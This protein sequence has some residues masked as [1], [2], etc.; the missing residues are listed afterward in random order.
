MPI[1]H[2]AFDVDGTL[3]DT[4]G[5]L[6]RSL[7]QALMQVV[8]SSHP[9]DVLADACIGRTETFTMNALEV[10]GDKRAEL[11][12]VWNRLTQE[13]R[14]G[15]SEV[16]DGA[17]AL[18]DALDE[19][20]IQHGIVTTRDA[21]LLDYDLGAA[22]LLERFSPVVTAECTRKHKP[23]P[24]PL[25]RYLE[26]TGADA[27]ETLYVG[28]TEGDRLC[29]ERAGVPFCLATWGTERSVD[30]AGARLAASFDELLAL[31]DEK[32]GDR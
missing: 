12:R 6:I 8:G 17:S 21:Y 26:L 28:D 15:A 5:L 32:N 10:P 14:D 9:S 11:L 3:V 1:T 29:A 13:G 20:G 22:G 27:A 16:F 30:P 7:D 25:L 24:D 23:E 31:V 2:I 18:L 4:E 19:R